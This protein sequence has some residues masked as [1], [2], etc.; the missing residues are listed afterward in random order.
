MMTQTYR[1]QAQHVGLE[2]PA[3]KQK[4]QRKRSGGGG[5]VSQYELMMG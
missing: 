5:G 4:K 2:V 3:K 1:V